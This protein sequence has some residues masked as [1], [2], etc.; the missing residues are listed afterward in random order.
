VSIPAQ[1]ECPPRRVAADLDSVPSEVRGQSVLGIF[2]MEA[3]C[4]AVQPVAGIV[5]AQR[6][7]NGTLRRRGEAGQTAVGCLA[8]GTCLRLRRTQLTAGRGC[9][10]ASERSIL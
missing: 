8:I 10:G 3:A 5:P 1:R 6:R 2:R 4:G 7:G 9:L